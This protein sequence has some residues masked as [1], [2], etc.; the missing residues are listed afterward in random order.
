MQDQD[1]QQALSAEHAAVHGYGVVGARL[2]G[3]R[4]RWAREAWN[5]HRAA[6]DRLRAELRAAGASPTPAAPDYALPSRVT[7]ADSAVRLALRLEE[8]VAAA[9]AELV[10]SADDELRRMAAQQMQDNAR[11]AA[12]WR[13][14]PV[15]F[16]GLPER[17]P[18]RRP[19]SPTPE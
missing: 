1:L 11:R 2:S 18:T 12:R 7:N 15:P 6:R 13:G 5:A 8:R 4:R 3:E 9:Y 17:R 10:A 14:A 16:P 19:P